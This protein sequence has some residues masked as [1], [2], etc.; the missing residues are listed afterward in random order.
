MPVL[1]LLQKLADLSSLF[2]FFVCVKVVREEEEEVGIEREKVE[3]VGHK[4]LLVR[5]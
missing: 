3:Q 4:T 1:L 5:V 2:V